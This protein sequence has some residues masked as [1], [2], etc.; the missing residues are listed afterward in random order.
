MSICKFTLILQVGLQIAQFVVNFTNFK[1]TS[2][3]VCQKFCEMHC[4]VNFHKTLRVP[5]PVIQCFTPFSL[6]EGR[7]AKTVCLGFLSHEYLLLRYLWCKRVFSQNEVLSLSL[8]FSLFKFWFYDNLITD[9]LQF[10]YLNILP[11]FWNS[12]ESCPWLIWKRCDIQVA[13]SKMMNIWKGMTS[14]WHSMMLKQH[15]IITYE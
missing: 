11:H 3:T 10:F 9:S 15:V 5:L 1:Q 13:R 2:E 14:F 7:W 8:K 6:R 12:F 4:N